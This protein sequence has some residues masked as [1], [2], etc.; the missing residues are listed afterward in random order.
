MTTIKS[1]ELKMKKKLILGLMLAPMLASASEGMWTFDNPPTERMKK[2]I[3]WAPDANWLQHTMQSSARLAL[4]CSG[5]F[6]SANGLVLSNHHC[7]AHCVEQISSD[8]T[9]YMQSGFLARSAAE[10][11]RCPA[12]EVNRLEKISD[13]SEAMHHATAGLE[14]EAFTKAQNA[15]TAKLSAECVGKDGDKV[16]CDVVS[17]YQGGKYNL[18]RYHRF[19]DVRL[20]FA[21]EQSVAFFGGDPDNFNFPR[22]DLDMSLLR[23]YEDGKPAT[24]SAYL[25]VSPTGPQAGEAVFTSGHPGSTQREYTM[26]RLIALR[27]HRLPEILIRLSE[28]RGL[29]TQFRA[30]GAEQSR[31]ANATL[32][33][34]EN[35]IKALSG[36]REALVEPSL[37]DAKQAEENALRKYVAG[38]PA[39]KASTGGAW[40]AIAKAIKVSD[41]MRE[42]L[43]QFEYQQAFNSDYA[44]FAFTLVRAA[45][46]RAKPNGE[47]LPE[48]ADAR[49]PQVQAGV[50]SPAPVYPDFEKVK[51]GWSLTKMRERLSPSNP[52]VVQ[53][54]GKDAPEQVAA[55]LIDGTKLG[56][57]AVRKALWDGGMKAIEQSDDPFIKLALQVDPIARALRK[58]YEARVESVITKANE[59]IAAARFAMLGTSIYPDATFSLRFSYGVVKGWKEAGKDVPPFTDFAG[60][61]EHATDADPFK[62]PERWYAAKDKLNLATPFNFVSTNDIIGGNSGSPMVNRKGEL[63]GLVFDGNIH[64]L[65]GAFGFDESV[66]RTVAVDSAALLEAMDKIYGAS[67]IANE[68]RGATK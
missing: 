58:D 10:E 16:R 9:N 44:H 20:V 39:L 61:F 4:G 67:A 5:S 57:P 50:L 13:V 41:E 22:F 1:G 40:D 19:Q 48:Y 26:A 32:F 35:S 45:A 52:Q 31:E 64:S 17:L 37:I 49:L 38:K 51:L 34:V 65:G 28:Y 12:M 24:I 55:R 62:L 59:K 11:Q 23:V 7:A 2:D 68:M 15:E 33:S 3:G 60:A 47:R 56:D 66:N 36:Q 21:P 27:D 8:K 6:V 18:Y 43:S 25:P 54:L 14:G 42:P 30:I 53:I 63:V 46:E 29:L